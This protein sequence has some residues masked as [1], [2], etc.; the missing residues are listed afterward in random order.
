MMAAIIANKI[1]VIHENMDKIVARPK[2][3]AR[4]ANELEFERLAIQTAHLA[5]DLFGGF[6]A[7]INRIANAMEGKKS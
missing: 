5:I 1:A 4:S 7:D 6:V 2:E 3:A